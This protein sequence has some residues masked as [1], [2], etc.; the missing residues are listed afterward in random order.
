MVDCKQ[1]I[2]VTWG[3]GECNQIG[4]IRTKDHDI[5]EIKQKAE[6]DHERVSFRCDGN[7][8]IRY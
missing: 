4:T 1:A 2:S 6:R 3:C 8:V 7:A 5:E